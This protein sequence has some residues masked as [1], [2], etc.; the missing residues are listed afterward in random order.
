MKSCDVRRATCSIGKTLVAVSF[1]F[2]LILT[3]F[4]G[5]TRPSVDRQAIEKV[6]LT[7]QQALTGKDIKLYLSIISPAYNDKGKD[8]ATE[9]RELE[10][11]FRSFERI[12]YRS[13]DRNIEIHGQQATVSGTYRISIV[14]KGQELSLEGTERIR[15]A[16][17]ADGW[18]IVGGL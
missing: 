10:A 11:N 17:G 3:F 8:Y 1:A 9:A 7:R 5:C 4:P 13:L 18:K 16:K 14:R 2:S 6:V 12:S 15:L